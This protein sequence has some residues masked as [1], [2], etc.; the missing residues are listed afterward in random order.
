MTQIDE[1]KSYKKLLDEGVITQEEFDTKKKE[2]LVDSSTLKDSASVQ[3]DEIKN[4]KNLLDEGV[5]TQEE[6][7][8]KKHELLSKRYAPSSNQAMNT[9]NFTTNAE[10]FIQSVK[11]VPAQTGNVGTKSKIAAGLLGIFLGIFGVHNFYLGYTSKAV[12]QLVLSIIGII[13]S[14]IIIGVF[15]FVAVE[16]W[17]F[18]EGIM[19]L[20]SSTGSRWHLDASGN[21]LRD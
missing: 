20:A 4:Y 14:I 19:I 11:S 5:I 10:G 1:L 17:G 9:Q 8:K 21:E 7:N 2:L 13:L 3:I 18:I 12:L 15:M 6:F 16:I